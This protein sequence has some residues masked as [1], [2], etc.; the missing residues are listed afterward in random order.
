MLK[1]KS[2]EP[3]PYSPLTTRPLSNHNV[4]T[5]TI[6]EQ[7]V[8]NEAIEIGYDSSYNLYVIRR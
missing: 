1:K 4:L 7:I 8:P 5:P 3:P 6:G 2:I